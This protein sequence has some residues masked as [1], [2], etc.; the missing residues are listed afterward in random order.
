MF[1]NDNPLNATDPLGLNP[2]QDLGNYIFGP[3][4]FD[5]PNTIISTYATKRY[6]TD[7]VNSATFSVATYR[8]LQGRIARSGFTLK[9]FMDAIKF[10]L[11]RPGDIVPQSNGSLRYSGPV[12]IIT[13][14]NGK[15]VS[16]KRY[17][18]VVAINPIYGNVITAWNMSDKNAV[19][20]AWTE[21]PWSG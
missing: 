14:E 4:H 7:S 2:L 3:Y 10:T 18:F 16:M 8:K 1:T 9:Q 17:A 6:N 12:A 13:S 19:N 11:G 15:I 21:G 20:K 5:T